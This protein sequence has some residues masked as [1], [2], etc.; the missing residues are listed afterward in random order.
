MFCARAEDRL[1]VCQDE[2]PVLWGS[3]VIYKKALD[4]G[5]GPPS[6]EGRNL[7]PC[8]LDDMRAW[9]SGLT[10]GF[11]QSYYTESYYPGQVENSRLRYSD[12]AG[13]WTPTL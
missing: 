4:L 1:V 8:S 7:N 3:L 12:S 2:F 11:S 10:V 13:M 9:L 6:T 5:I